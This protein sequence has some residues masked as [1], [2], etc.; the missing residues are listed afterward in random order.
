MYTTKRIYTTVIDYY[1]SIGIYKMKRIS[2]GIKLNK[3]CC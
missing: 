3:H 1:K 2:A